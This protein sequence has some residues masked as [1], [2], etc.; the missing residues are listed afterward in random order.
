VIAALQGAGGLRAEV[1]VTGTV[2]AGDRV[3]V[4]RRG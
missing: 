2:T 4:P 3:E 1:V